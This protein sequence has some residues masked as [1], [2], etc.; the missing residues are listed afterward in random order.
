LVVLVLT[1]M[2]ER[3]Q[4]RLSTEELLEIPLSES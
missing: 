4:E 1:L 3:R 2:V